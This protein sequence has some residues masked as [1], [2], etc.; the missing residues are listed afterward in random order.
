MLKSIDIRTTQNVTI[1]YEL[2]YLRERIFAFLL[3]TILMVLAM[4]FMALLV[5]LSGLFNY[6][7]G[8]WDYFQFLVILPIR[9]FYTLFFESLLNGQTPGKMVLRIKV[10]KM[11]GKQPSFS[12][13]L[14]RWCFRL[15]DLWLTFGVLGS[16][17][18]IS[19]DYGQRLG[20]IVSNTAVVR[21]QPRLLVG[22]KDIMRI[23]TLSNYTPVYKDIRH[24][25]EEDILVIK[26]TIERY[27]QYRNKAH[28]E[29]VLELCETVK[30]R[31]SIETL[32]GNKIEFL[33]GLIK[34]YIVLTR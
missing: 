14:M 10:V 7:D 19:T 15:V 4:L 18:I 11:D 29:A 21:V 20:D 22:L 32:P 28:R 34:D 3:D 6:F 2:A 5:S 30:E 24:F 27:N 26:Q 33:K 9:S 25:R 8:G 12:D 31:L 1:T 23:D 13:F 17:L 16:L